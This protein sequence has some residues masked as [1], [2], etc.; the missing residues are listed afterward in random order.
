MYNSTR[1]QSLMVS[2]SAAILKGLADDGGLFVSKK[3]PNL[4]ADLE[5]LIHLDYQSLAVEILSLFLND[6]RKEEIAECVANGY[7]KFRSDPPLKVQKLGNDI[8]LELF[9]G[10]T[11]AFKDMALSVLPSLL[12]K[13][14]E[15]QNVQEDL[16]ILTA[17]SGDTG[18]AALSGIKDT[19]RLKAAAFFPD[20]AVSEI[21]KRQ[22]LRE[23]SANT[24]C[25]ALKGNFDDC[26]RAVKGLFKDE[27]FIEDI[28]AR[29]YR[30]STANSI[31]I[32]RLLLQIVYYF[33]VYGEAVRNKTIKFYEKLNVVVPSG[34]FGNIL[35]AYYAKKMGLP[36]NKLICASNQNKVLTDFFNSGV[37]DIKREFKLSISPSMD[38]LIASNLERLLYHISSDS[39]L[40]KDLME[41]LSTTGEFV[42]PERLR[43][44]LR[45]FE[46]Y[47]LS[48]SE[49]LATIKK[50]QA[51][52]GYIFDT[53]SAVA[54]GAL[55]SYKNEQNDS[56]PSV[57]VSTASPYKF[58]P[59][60]LEALGENV[61]GDLTKDLE[62]LAQINRQELPAVIRELLVENKKEQVIESSEIQSVINAFCSGSHNEA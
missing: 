53:H 19:K 27:R 38:I 13:S 50:V 37:Y 24:T 48:E 60:V 35:A 47:S 3:L 20:G 9:H 11:L 5:R 46:A 58:A 49:T 57:V 40:V 23:S 2:A 54:W 42:L 10:Q 36:L 61:S 33:Y 41:D 26:Q 15:K 6:F 44:K 30:L 18:S 28:D 12:V 7:S 25:Y 39:E 16:L 31:N 43:R 51:E 21:Q 4:N 56:T 8:V 32:A 59:A 22:M 14:L 62:T 29:G 1:N 17:T 52:Y 45:D 55:E 34:N